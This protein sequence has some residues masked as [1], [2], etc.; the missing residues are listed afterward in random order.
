MLPARRTN[1]GVTALAGLL[2]LGCGGAP[3]SKFPTGDAALE[4]MHATYACSRGIRGEAE[5]DYFG[6][7]GRVRG[8]L[9]YLAVLPDQL[10]M[11]VYSPF[12]V[13]VSTLTSDGKDFAL[14]DLQHATYLHGPAT[15]CNV[16]RFTQVPVPPFALVELTRGEAPVLVHTPESIRVRWKRRLRGG[17]YVVHVESKHDA[18]QDIELMVHPADVDKPWTEQRVTVSSVVVRQGGVTLYAADLRGH[19]AGRTAAGRADPDGLGEDLLPSGP[20]CDAPVPDRLRLRVPDTEQELIFDNERIG[21]DV[22]HNPPL[23]GAEFVQA[24]PGGVK[25]VYAECQ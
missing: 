16:A 14:Y 2:L 24:V 7:E 10:R 6:K 20:P 13:V 4:R 1:W 19:T 12:G 9:L 11:D 8:S 18:E 17:S 23:T 15:T 3:R 22:V 21:K 5:V 25:V